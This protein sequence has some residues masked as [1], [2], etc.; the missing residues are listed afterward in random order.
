MGITWI[1]NVLFFREE[2]LFVAYII[3]I[4]IACQGII[5]FILFVPLSKQVN[6]NEMQRNICTCI[7]NSKFCVDMT[8]L[9]YSS[10]RRK[11]TLILVM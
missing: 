3:T 5:I 11:L 4:F 10:E 2:L 7:N 1:G 9:K 8:P 6:Y